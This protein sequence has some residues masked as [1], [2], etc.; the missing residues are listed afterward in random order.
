MSRLTLQSHSEWVPLSEPWCI[1]VLDCTTAE[2]TAAFG[3]EWDQVD[4]EGLGL[5]SYALLAWEGR[6]RFLL[7]ASGSYPEN[8]VSIEASA[9]EDAAHARHDFLSDL[10]LTPA[11]LLAVSE[12]GVWFA[13]W[14]PP[15]NAGERPATATRRPFES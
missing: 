11:A 15:Q 10:G 5:T 1:G 2:A 6:S 8:G 3:W 14:D 4:E 12:A 13:R 7:S 9:S